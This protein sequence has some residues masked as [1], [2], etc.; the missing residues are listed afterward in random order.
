MQH[1]KVFRTWAVAPSRAAARG[2]GQRSPARVKEFAAAADILCEAMYAMIITT[3]T[4]IT[5][6]FGLWAGAAL[7]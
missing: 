7:Q 1:R 4:T 3:T 5:R 6:G 2:D